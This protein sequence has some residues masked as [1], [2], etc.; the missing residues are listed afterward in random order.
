MTTLLAGPGQPAKHARPTGKMRGLWEASPLTYVALIVAVALSLFPIYWMIVVATRTNDVVSAVPPPLV[1]G[2]EGGENVGRLF[3]N[4][5]AYFA[6]GLLNSAIASTVVTISTVFFASLAGFAFAKLRF[7]G[8]NGLLLTIIATM[9]IPVQMGIIPLYMIMV[10]LGW[11]NQLQAVIVPFLV[12][13]FGVFMMR[14]Y[15]SQA[16]PDELIE[17]ARVDGCT[18]FGIYWR[19]VMPA[20]RPAAG[21]LG[22]LTFMQTWNEFMWPLAV[23]APDNPTVQ[24]SINNLANAYFDDYTLMF[25]GTTVAVLPLLVVFIV[26]GRQIIGGIMEGA[27]KA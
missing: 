26:F 13:G 8:K 9:M 15:A 20:L 1:P 23:L 27:V 10:E 17:A 2:G 4:P 12:T 3:D 14:Q 7:K 22:L 16:I 11:Q 25:A 5:D 24:L 19:V 6:Q 21:V 18:T